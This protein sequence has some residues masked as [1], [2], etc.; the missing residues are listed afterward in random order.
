VWIS[1][2]KEKL[3]ICQPLDG[4]RLWRHDAEKTAPQVLRRVVAA[5]APTAAIGIIGASVIL[6]VAEVAAAKAVP[7]Y[8]HAPAK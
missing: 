8:A 2:V 7:V 5:V 1:V 6:G 3:C 4:H